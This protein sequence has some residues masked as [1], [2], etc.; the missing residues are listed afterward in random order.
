ML[1]ANYLRRQAEICLNLSRATFDLV[2]AGRLRT[3]AAELD[4]KATKLE[5]EDHRLPGHSE[6]ELLARR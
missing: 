2:V 1:D 5:D 3:M 6:A 4:T